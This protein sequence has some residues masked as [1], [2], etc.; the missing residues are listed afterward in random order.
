MNGAHDMGGMQNFGPVEVE[1]NE[2]VFHGRWEQR[3]FA[4]TLAMGATGTWNLDMSRF[5]RESLPPAQYLAS[6]YYQIWFEGLRNLIAETGLASTEEM[7]SGRMI[8][9]PA[10]VARVI[11]A[12]EI[13][14]ALKKG[15]PTLREIEQGP[16]FKPGDKVRTINSHPAGHTRLPRYMRGHTGEI[17]RHHGAHVFADAHAAGRGEMPQHLYA[18]RFSARELW[19]EDAH[20]NDCVHA[21]LWESYLEPA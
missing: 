18:V 6:S 3:A 8:D 20:A 10:P 9:P 15:A 4:L 21:D 7:D 12:D 13:G 17:A 19:G 14:I 5:A 1:P 11:K 16:R 2:P